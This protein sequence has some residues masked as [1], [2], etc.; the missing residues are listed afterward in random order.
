MSAVD[1]VAGTITGMQ[2]RPFREIRR[3]Y[4]YF[5]EGDVLFAKITPCMQNGK[6]AIAR[7]LADGLGFG[8]TEFHV[9]RPGPD[10]T[11]EWVHRWVRRLEF[12][13]AAERHFRGAVGQ[14]RVQDEFVASAPIPVPPLPEQRRIVAKLDAIFARAREAKRLRESARDDTDRILEALVVE[15]LAPLSVVAFGTLVEDYRNGI[16]KQKEFYGRGV[17]SIRMY[18]IAHGR[19]N[20][21]NAPLLDVTDEELETYGLLPGDVLVNRVNSREL[22]GKTGLV[23]D[24]LGPCTFESKNIRARLKRTMIEPAFAAAALNSDRVRRQ[25]QAMVKPA[26]G[27]ATINQGNLDVIELPYADLAR[28]REIVALI[29]EVQDRTADLRLAQ[30]GSEAELQAIEDSVLDRAFRGEL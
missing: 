4:T 2:T 29:A 22:V 15:A 11:A 17:P 3:G 14:Q 19:V 24:D 7:N 8:S 28:Q 21:A 20:K 12:R 18:N 30:H 10:V 6:S 27:Q 1:E 23:G 25:I 9:L 5:A 26:I 16:Y 13:R